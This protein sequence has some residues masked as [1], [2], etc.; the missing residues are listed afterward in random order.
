[1]I[2]INPAGPYIGLFQFHPTTFR[3]YGGKDIY[4]PYDQSDVAARMFARGWTW[5]R[6]RF[7]TADAVTPL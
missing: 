5:V 2:P 7:A 6:S 4:D 3:A 1:M